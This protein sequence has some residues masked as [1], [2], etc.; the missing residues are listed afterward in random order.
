MW[1]LFITILTIP[2]SNILMKKGMILDVDMPNDEKYY[3]LSIIF[4]VPFINVIVMF[5]YLLWQ[6]IRFKRP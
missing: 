1:W 6:I 5:C 2:L 3:Y 4:Y